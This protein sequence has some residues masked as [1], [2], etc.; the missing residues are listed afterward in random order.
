MVGADEGL[1]HQH[2]ISFG[3]GKH[4]RRCFE[5]KGNWEVKHFIEGATSST[6]RNGRVGTR[7]SNSGKRRH[8]CGNCCGVDNLGGNQ[9]K[10]NGGPQTQ[11][12]MTTW[13]QNRI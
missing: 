6:Q 12:F 8:M 9:T 13:R 4:Y 11:I 1:R 5:S 10:A 2:L 3:K 7:T